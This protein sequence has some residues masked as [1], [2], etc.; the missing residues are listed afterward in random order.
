MSSE[1]ACISMSDLLNGFRFGFKNFLF[2]LKI[3]D[4][5]SMAAI[6]NV[7]MMKSLTRCEESVFK[8]EK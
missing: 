7:I 5:I 3:V 1:N 4:G 6:G 2:F 8:L